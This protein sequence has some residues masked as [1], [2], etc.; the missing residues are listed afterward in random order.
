MQLLC[1]PPKLCSCAVALGVHSFVCEHRQRQ[2]HLVEIQHRVLDQ[3]SVRNR[4]CKGIEDPHR[5]LEN[6]EAT[7][8][9]WATEATEDTEAT[10]DT[11]ATEDIETTEAT[12]AIDAEDAYII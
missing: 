10:G 4:P 1:I 5:R 2:P 8:A 3:A 12:E 11:E 6:T 7:E 9:A